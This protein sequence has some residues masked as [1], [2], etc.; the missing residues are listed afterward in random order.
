VRAVPFGSGFIDYGAFL[1]G[2]RDGGFDG[3]AVYEICS[4]VRG[5]GSLENL[6][7]CAGKYLQWLRENQFEKPSVDRSQARRVALTPASL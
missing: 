2:L 4:P 1:Q 7:A 5:G 6:D 3:I